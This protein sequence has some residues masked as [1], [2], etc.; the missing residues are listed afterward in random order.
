MPTAAQIALGAQA[1]LSAGLLMKVQTA[2]PLFSRFDVRTSKSM[3]VLTLAMNSLPSPSRFVKEG[4]GVNGSEG[5]LQLV[6]FNMAKLKGQLRQ[7]KDSAARWDAEHLASGTTWW[8]LQAMGKMKADALNIE[9]QIINGIGNDVEG[10]PGARAITPFIAGNTF[11]LTDDTQAQLFT[12]SVLNV[13][14]STAN[15]GSSIYSFVFGQLDC[16]LVWGNYLGGELFS[17]GNIVEQYLPPDPVNAPNDLLLYQIADLTAYM[18]LSV[19]GFNPQTAGE[20]IPT[21]YSLRR[22]ANITAQEGKTASSAVLDKLS[23]SHGIGILPDLL[24]M[25]QRSGEQLAIECTPTVTQF[26][27]GVS[28]NASNAAFNRRPPPPTT[29]NVQGKEIPIVYPFCIGSTDAIEA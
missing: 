18:G 16:Q 13:T 1:E 22:A 24:A 21:Q 9:K 2:C 4:Q 3:R 11:I 17:I 7:E 28:G 23:R 26:L 15:T 8:D 14:G 27:M 5:T 19:A 12:R 25:S 10:F 29:W 20:A 6:E